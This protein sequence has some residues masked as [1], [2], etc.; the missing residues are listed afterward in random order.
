VPADALLSRRLQGVEMM[1]RQPVAAESVRRPDSQM[2]ALDCEQPARTDPR[3]E[4]GWRQTAARRLQ[5]LR[6]KAI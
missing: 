4:D 5:Y 1:L 6:P 2:V 3:F